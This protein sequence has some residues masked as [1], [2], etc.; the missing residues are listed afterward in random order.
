MTNKKK[1]IYNHKK[2]TWKYNIKKQFLNIIENIS[3]KKTNKKKI[4]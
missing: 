4:C 3:D 2:N 1:T